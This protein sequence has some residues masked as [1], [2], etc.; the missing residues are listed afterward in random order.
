[1]N[2][3]VFLGSLAAAGIFAGLGIHHFGLACRLI[4]VKNSR[5]DLLAP[6]AADTGLFINDY[7]HSASVIIAA[8]RGNIISWCPVR[9]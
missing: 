4:E 7:I 3:T 8:R 5:T 6:S 1:M 2:R 9:E